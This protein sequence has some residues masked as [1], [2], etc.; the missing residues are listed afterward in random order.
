MVLP[1]LKVFWVGEDDSVS[2]VGKKIVGDVREAVVGWTWMG[3]AC[4]AGDEACW[5]GL[6]G[7]HTGCHSD[8]SCY[9]IY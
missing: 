1:R 5:L 8:L 3:F 6:L 7:S 2:S 9:E 4:A